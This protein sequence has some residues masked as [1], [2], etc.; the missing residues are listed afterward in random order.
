M[1]SAEIYVGLM[2]GTS[3]DGV[4]AAAVDF[5]GSGLRLLG[6]HF[7]PYDDELRSALLAAHEPR[8]NE[9]HE[10]ALLGNRVAHLYGA[11]TQGLL[12]K[13]R[14]KPAD[15]QALGCHGQTVRHRPEAGYT[16]QLGNGALLA[17]LTTVTTV[18]DFRS[19][20]IAAGG[21]G[22]PLVPAFHQA[23]FGH[24]KVHRAALNIGGIANLTDLPPRGK[25][26][27]FDTGPG[28]LLMDAWAQRHLGEAFDRDGAW[29]ASGKPIDSLLRE[30]LREPYFSAVPPKSTGRDLFNLAWLEQRLSG[31]EATS[32]VQATLLALTVESIARD[33]VAHCSGAREIY[34][35]GGGAANP[36]LMS[37]L[38]A[39]LAER[40]VLTTAVLGIDP[41][42]VEACAFAWLARQ[43]LHLKAGN[44]PAVTGANG[45]RVLGAIYP[46]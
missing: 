21:Q 35:C 39:R 44:L 5:S 3:L 32:D 26:H 18:C 41:D 11:A 23:M 9:L 29:A 37:R 10:S 13:C 28:N 43:A 25:V 33:L 8:L 12:R 31:S 38:G 1:P 17:E 36:A 14:I 22:A 30:L 15:V 19:R 45:P 16:I 24:G 40:K 34:V 4:D 27:G 7:L 46:R 20:D 6:T 2:S 42:W